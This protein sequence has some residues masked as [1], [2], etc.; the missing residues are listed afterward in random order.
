[1]HSF[2]LYRQTVNYTFFSFF[3]CRILEDMVRIDVDTTYNHI[4]P[5]RISQMKGC[6]CAFSCHFDFSF[7]IP[8]DTSASQSEVSTHNANVLTII[9]PS[10]LCVFYVNSIHVIFFNIM[11]IIRVST[12]CLSSYLKRHVI[13]H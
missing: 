4:Q 8:F 12:A 3:F 6:V 1:M 11:G 13:P 10:K 5:S 9:S 7:K 2:I